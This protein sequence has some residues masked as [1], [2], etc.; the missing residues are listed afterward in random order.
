MILKDVLF[1]IFFSWFRNP[2]RTSFMLPVDENA[3]ENHI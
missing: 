2:D 1:F 3:A